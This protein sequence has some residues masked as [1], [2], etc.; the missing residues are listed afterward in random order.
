LG[1]PALRL[2]DNLA[3]FEARAQTTDILSGGAGRVAHA[4]SSAL[5]QRTPARDETTRAAEE[6]A[7]QRRPV[8]RIL[9]TVIVLALPTPE[10]TQEAQ[11]AASA[12]A[13]EAPKSRWN[14]R[15]GSV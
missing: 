7:S 8:Q 15:T 4:S 14:G 10:Y 3:S 11:A 6:K 9:P 12:L 5:S 13:K 1:P 2:T